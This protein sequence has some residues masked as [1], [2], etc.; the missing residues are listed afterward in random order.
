MAADDARRQELSLRICDDLVHLGVVDGGPG[1]RI[2]GGA[3]A[4]A[5]DLIVCA[6]NDHSVRA[7]ELGRTLANGDLL[8]IEVV[9]GRGLSRHGLS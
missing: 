6:R 3:T 5:G 8:R 9:T 2:T 1:V 4:S 7:G